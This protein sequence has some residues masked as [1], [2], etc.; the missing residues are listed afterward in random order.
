MSDVDTASTEDLADLLRGLRTVVI[1]GAGIS[2]E[3]GIPDYRGVDRTGPPPTPVTYQQFVRDAR[4][5]QRYWARSTLGW[6][7]MRSRAPNAGHEAVA[8]LEHARQVS[9]VI[10][11]NVDGLHRAAGS[12]AV[13]ELHGSL[14]EVV[15]LNCGTRESRG[16]LQARLESL[17][18]GFAGRSVTILPDGDAAIPDEWIA[19]FVVAACTVCGGVLKTD[20]VF[21]GE[22]V[23]K[24]RAAAAADMVAGASAV[25][26]L[27]SSLEARSGLRLVLAA[28]QD[29]KPV[30]VVNRGPTRAD[31]VATLR[32]EA[33]LGEVL[34]ALAELLAPSGAP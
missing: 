17:N 23:P 31:D 11:Q 14:A 28:V 33:R 29:G 5:R 32:I 20:V 6:P 27:G 8:R 18:P 2:T 15:C 25:L 16:A 34:P 3:S 30:A 7:A 13:V 9:G 10:T 19:E 21:F 26:V 1:S 22:N 4:V 24:E 12:R